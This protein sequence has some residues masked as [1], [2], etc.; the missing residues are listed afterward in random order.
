MLQTGPLL[1]ALRGLGLLALA[2]GLA[3]SSGCTSSANGPPGAAAAQLTPA[4][5]DFG[6]QTVGTTTAAKSITLADV[7]NS[8][9]SISAIDVTGD[10]AQ[11]N[12]CDTAVAAGESCTIFI[13]FTPTLSG[14]RTGTLS[15]VDNAPGSPHTVTLTGTAVPRPPTPVYPLAVS[16][17]GRYLVDH[18]NTPWRVQA[19]A[20][21][22]MASAATPDLVDT[23]LATRKAQGFNSFYLM[24]MVHEGGNSAFAP[25]APANYIGDRPFEA[26][27]GGGGWDFSTAGNTPSSQGYWAWVD[28]IIDKAAAQGMVV[29]LAFTYLGYMGGNQGWAQ[30][31]LAQPSR[32]ALTAWGEWL[33]LRYRNKPNILWFALGDDTPAPGSELEARTL[34]IIQGIN[35]VFA[36]QLFLAEPSGGNASPMLD[37]PAFAPYL[38]MN[39]FYGYGS[40]GA[41]DC[42]AQAARAYAMSPPAPAWV[43]EG[44][45]EF[46]DNTGSFTGASYETRRT[47]FWAVLA[48]GTAGDGFGSRDAYTFQF[49]NADGLRTPG[50]E[51]STNAFQLFAT[52]DWWNLLPSGVGPGLAGKTLVTSGGGTGDLGDLSYVTA[53]VTANGQHLLAYIPTVGGTE[54]RTLTVDMTAMAGPTRARWW[55]PATGVYTLIGT[56]LPNTGPS[57]FASPGP[58][59]GGQNDW[60]LVLDSPG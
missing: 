28:T 10:F 6:N 49:K 19:D 25:A 43:E 17:N 31:I 48:G 11:T 13:T 29:M 23:Y 54:S 35:N 59:G 27:D 5:L 3:V 33:G 46:E 1:L 30:D 52:F 57:S 41:G 60:V 53:A 55:D 32:A 12:G 18:S 56:A 24:A 8:A 21:W 42:Y 22:L 26:L 44:G 58:N 38:N 47:R 39:S 37:A 7:G 40:T 2:V 15:I 9:L 45:Y 36:A 50:A 14:D 34:A 20:A 16:A 51:F 4:A